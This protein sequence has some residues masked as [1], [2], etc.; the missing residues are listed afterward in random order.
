MNYLQLKC[1]TAYTQSH[2]PISWMY[3]IYKVWCSVGV[4]QYLH[5]ERQ[6]MEGSLSDP[7][8]ALWAM[9]HVLWANK[10]PSNLLDY[11]MINTE[12]QPWV[13]AG[14]FSGYIDNG[15][16]HTKQL[17]HKTKEKHLPP[18]L[19]PPSTPTVRTYSAWAA[20]YAVSGCS[21]AWKACVPSQGPSYTIP[22]L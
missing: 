3:L 6:Q 16:I 17:P 13:N 11:S 20:D 4:Q 12:F 8:R 1:V 7:R 2:Q 21:P 19:P 15:V 18:A 9:C 22:F 5:S 10:F 14:L